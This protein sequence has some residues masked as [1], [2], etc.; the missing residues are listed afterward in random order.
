MINDK[1]TAHSTHPGRCLHVR[2][3]SDSVDVESSKQGVL[4][5]GVLGRLL[6]VAVH[7]SREDALDTA[8]GGRCCE[9]LL[10]RLFPSAGHLS[11]LTFHQSRIVTREGHKPRE[12]CLECALSA[13]P[14]LAKF[15]HCFLLETD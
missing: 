7:L 9:V 1:P 13:P 8:R 3:L 4:K 14:V 15:H 6:Q 11:A 12:Y 10:D 2:S 5:G